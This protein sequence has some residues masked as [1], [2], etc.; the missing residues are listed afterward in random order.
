MRGRARIHRPIALFQP[1][2]RSKTMLVPTRALRIDPVAHA[3]RHTPCRSAAR[4]RVRSIIA[5]PGFADCDISAANGCEIDIST[6]T[7]CGA[8]GRACA[9][10]TCFNGACSVQRSCPTPGERGCGLVGVHGGS[11]VMGSAE[12]TYSAVLGRVSVSDFLVDSHEVTLSRFRRFWAAGHP[13]P[14]ASIR[15]PGGALL[16]SGT[17]SEPANATGCADSN[18]T[19]VAGTREFHPLNCV[20]WSTAQAFCVWDGGRLPTEA[21]LEFVGRGRSIDG[22]PT[23]RDYP[24]GNETVPFTWPEP[25]VC[26]RAHYQH[27]MGEDGARTRRVGSFPPT[28]GVYD[29]AGN[30]AEVAADDWSLFGSGPCWAAGTSIMANPLCTDDVERHAGRG[31]SFGAVTRAALLVASREP[32]SSSA[33]ESELGFRCVRS[34]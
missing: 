1:R 29:L 2:L 27:C 30:L 4:V 22:I 6:S 34:P 21:E 13:R 18:W 17:V 16:G 7:D 11:F 31:G 28:G 24:W 25:T 10:G 14:A 19:S 33:G 12:P 9:G 3:Q 23:P 20:T 15:Y 32:R 8:C 26:T 5:R